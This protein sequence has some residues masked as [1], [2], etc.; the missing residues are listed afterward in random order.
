MV[1]LWCTVKLI[2]AYSVFVCHHHLLPPLQGLLLYGISFL[3]GGDS[4]EDF[5]A[6]WSSD[7]VADW[8]AA[9]FPPWGTQLAIDMKQE[10]GFTCTGVPIQCSVGPVY[11]GQHLGNHLSEAAC[12]PWPK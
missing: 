12:L 2:T 5:I 4:H 7:E 10:V 8:I 9:E 6:T 1:Q 11:S 3:S